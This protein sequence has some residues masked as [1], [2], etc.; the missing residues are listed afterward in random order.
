LLVK[1]L[2]DDDVGLSERLLDIP[3]LVTG[4][5]RDIVLQRRV[6]LGRAFLHRLFR[7]DDRGQ[8]LVL[9]LDGSSRVIGAIPFGCQH[10]GDRCP[11]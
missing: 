3:M 9:D 8:W 10:D 7:I 5:Q 4:V 6:E 11:T 1:T 2:L